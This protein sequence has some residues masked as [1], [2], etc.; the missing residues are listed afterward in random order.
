MK[1]YI[2]F[3]LFYLFNLFNVSLFYFIDGQADEERFRR[4]AN[5]LKTNTF[6]VELFISGFDIGIGHNEI[7]DEACGLM[8]ESLKVNTTLKDLTISSNLI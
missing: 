6:L 7:S 1:V 5:A 2:L 3:V 4:I 8:G